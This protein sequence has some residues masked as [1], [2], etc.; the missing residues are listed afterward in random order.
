MKGAKLYYTK[1]KYV[2][3]LEIIIKQTI[4]QTTSLQVSVPPS[5]GT[6]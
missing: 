4:Q 3:L 6:F 1:C 5:S 2:R